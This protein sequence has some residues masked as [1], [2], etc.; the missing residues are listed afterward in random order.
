MG[1]TPSDAD[2]I[3]TKALEGFAR[4]F[5]YA[6]NGRYGLGSVEPRT[7]DPEVAKSRKLHQEAIRKVMELARACAPRTR[8]QELEQNKRP[9]GP[10]FRYSFPFFNTVRRFRDDI[11]LRRYNREWIKNNP[12]MTIAEALQASTKKKPSE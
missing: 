8:E 11:R 2:F 4:H 6:I 12:S 10:S 3:N 5:D 9:R 7:V 1:D